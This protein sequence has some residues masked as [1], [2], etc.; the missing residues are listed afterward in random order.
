MS[1]RLCLIVGAL[2]LGAGCKEVPTSVLLRVSAGDGLAAPDELRLDVYSEAGVELRNNRLPESGRPELPAEVALF[3]RQSSGDLQIVVQARLGQ[4]AI[5]EGWAF[6]RLEAGKQVRAEVIVRPGLLTDTD[7]DGVPDIVD[8]CPRVKNPDQDPCVDV[9]AAIPRD[10]GPA[11][12]RSTPDADIGPT[13]GPP[14]ALAPCTCPLGC[15]G[16]SSICRGLI[17]SGGFAAKSHA[18]IPALNTSTAINTTVCRVT[19][20]GKTVN[21]SLQPAGGG[22]ACVLGLSSLKVGK[23]VTLSA[24]GDNPLVILVSGSVTVDGTIDI[25]A[26]GKVPGP[27]G[28]AGG[29]F[30]STGPGQPGGGP[31][32]GKVCSCALALGDDCGGGG[33]GFGGAGGAGGKELSGSCTSVSSGGALY[34]TAA[35][36]PLVGGSGGASAGQEQLNDGVGAGGA[37]GGALQIS[38][39]EEI[40]VNGAIT[41]GGGG[42]LAGV[43]NSATI[44]PAGGGGGGSGGAILLEA[45][46]ISGSGLVAANGGGGA[47]GGSTAGGA[48]QAGENGGPKLGAAKGGAGGTN[49]GAGGAGGWGTTAAKAGGD[50]QNQ[51]GGGGGGGA[52]GRVRL[53]WYQHGTTPPLAVSGVTSLGEVTVK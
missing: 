48:G 25:G 43:L 44:S 11:L 51:N 28:A 21:G 26:K 27:G 22:Q 35:L 4:K 29:V 31:G 45:A 8:N 7:G 15:L 13:D 23:G 40:I 17:P 34:G 37:G 41:A 12:E 16:D 2:L 42:G 49:S 9:D 36:V 6:V 53:N 50:G 5:G 38:A 20:N 1:P 30:P 33:G 39:Q 24:T 14:D 18:S 32:G 47:G 10:L 46:T 3:P 52:A 19:V